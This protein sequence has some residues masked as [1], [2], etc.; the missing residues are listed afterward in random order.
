MGS[1]PEASRLLTTSLRQELDSFGRSVA[2]V[3]AELP[4]LVTPCDLVDSAKVCTGCGTGHARGTE[5]DI[6]GRLI[7]LL[8]MLRAEHETL[9]RARDRAELLNEE[10]QRF[11]GDM[12]SE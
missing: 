10:A 11:I 7:A 12:S 2:F 3:A 9:K 1:V 6:E 4:I 8:S 5:H